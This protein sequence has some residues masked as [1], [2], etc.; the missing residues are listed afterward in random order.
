MSAK[1][2]RKK[3][4]NP[5]PEVLAHE[6]GSLVDLYKHSE[7]TLFSIFNFY[8]T[9]LTT[10]T[11]AIVVIFQISGKNASDPL[12]TIMVLLVFIVLIGMITQDALIH[13]N[14]DLSHYA[15]AINA[16]KEYAVGEHTEL[17]SRLF[18]MWDLH[19]RVNPLHY[20]ISLDEKLD[21]YL[22][23]MLPIGMPQLFVS[24]MNSCALAA[25]LTALTYKL[26]GFARINLINFVLTIAFVIGLSF[27]AHCTYAN[28][29]YRHSIQRSAMTMDG[30]L[31][32]WAK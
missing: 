29:K 23:W 13:K 30:Q 18:Y 16:L 4:A 9:L 27:I 7:N 28:I 32:E 15:L 25:F 14:A 24:L 10:I 5:Q 26:D 8:V 22:W 3:G 19:T 1:Q 31:Q 17:R 6:Y 2:P 21:K 20:K 11:G 12:G